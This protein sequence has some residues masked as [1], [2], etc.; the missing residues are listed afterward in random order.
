L[1]MD[2]SDPHCLDD[3]HG[4]MTPFLRLF[5]RLALPYIQVVHVGIVQ[6]FNRLSNSQTE[7]VVVGSSHGAHATVCSCASALTSASFSLSGTNDCQSLSSRHCRLR[8]DEV[9]VIVVVDV[10]LSYV[11]WP[12][13]AGSEDNI[14]FPVR[15]V[16]PGC[17]THVLT[18]HGP[19]IS[20][21]SF[22][23]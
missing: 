19:T 8:D 9:A 2:V 14:F 20:I 22:P 4:P 23:S 3:E 18:H 6:F 10:S 11:L 15:N 21:V 16:T 7:S 12:S 5:L 13:A 1:C 17:Q